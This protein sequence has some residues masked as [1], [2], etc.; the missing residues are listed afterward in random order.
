MRTT[1]LDDPADG[2][3]EFLQSKIAKDGYYYIKVYETENS[4]RTR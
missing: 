1:I 2:P 3:T 4:A